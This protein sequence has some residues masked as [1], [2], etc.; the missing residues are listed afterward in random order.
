MDARKVILAIDQGTTGS[1]ALVLDH[2]LRILGRANVEYAQHFP[3]PGWV[4]HDLDEIWESVRRATSSALKEAGVGGGSVAAI[5]ITNQRETTCLWRRESR[6]RALHR[7]I[8]W[9]DRRTAVRCET[10]KKRA[11]LEAKIRRTT[12]LLLDPYFS[13]TKMEWLLANVEGARKLAEAGEA[14]FGTIDSYLLFRLTGGQSHKTDVSN[15]SR[16]MLMD[17]KKCEWDASLLK[18]F[19]VPRASLPEIAPSAVSYGETRG[20]EVVPDGV[21]ITGIVGDQQA[22]LFGQLCLEPGSGK[23]TYGTGAFAVVN[24]GEKP[25]FSKNRLLTTVAWKFGKKTTY[26]LEGSA[27]IAGAAV[28]WLRDGLK[29]IARSPDVER[30]AAEEKDSDGVVFVPALT[31]IGAPH[32]EPSATGLFV[33]LTRRTTRGHIARATLEGIAHSV[34]DLM[35]A[36]EADLGRPLRTLKADGGAAMD[37]LLLQAQADFLGRTIVRPEIV[38][39]TALGAAMMAGLGIGFWR[40]VDELRSSWRQAV[41]LEPKMS[42]AERASRRARWAQAIEAVKLLAAPPAP[43]GRRAGKARVKARRQSPRRAR[44]R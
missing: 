40:D 30:V 29:M 4:E 11:G 10:L 35:E 24:T 34:A 26:G 6:A 31:G 15:A 19:G 36:M 32:W 1:T 25:I 22:A 9:Q 20:F 7:A 28:Q 23:C 38:E 37:L 17:L 33:G 27:F 12:G 2:A 5:G 39:T 44:R 13:A 14:L 8:V 43:K 3:E 18:L 16:T 42:D 21:P 41:A